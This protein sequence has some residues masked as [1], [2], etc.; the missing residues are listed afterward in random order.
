MPFYKCHKDK[1][2]YYY[3]FEPNPLSFKE[4]AKQIKEYNIPNLT[5]LEYAAWHE[6]CRREMWLSIR[7][8]RNGG[9]KKRGGASLFSGKRLLG[10]VREAV[11]CIDFDKWVKKNLSK[12]D[13]IHLRMDIEGAEYYVLPKMIKGGSMDYISSLSIEFHAYKFKGENRKIFNLIHKELKEYFS[14]C[15]NIEILKLQGIEKN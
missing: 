7:K 3:L 12:E 10:K 9:Y 15:K 1:D 6:E 14:N 8:N 13:Y 4:I 11:D 5:L 2:W